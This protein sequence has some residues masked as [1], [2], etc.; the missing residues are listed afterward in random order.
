MRNNK[1]EIIKYKFICI[2]FIFLILQN[3]TAKRH[4]L[5]FV[6]ES[7]RHIFLSQFGYGWNGT[8]AFILANFTVPKAVLDSGN[9]EKLV[10]FLCDNL[11]L[12]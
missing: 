12:N 1:S 9:L 4:L 8:F 7:R 6:D 5:S 3:A 10:I 2:S 11:I